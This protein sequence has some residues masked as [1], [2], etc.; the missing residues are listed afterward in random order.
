MKPAPSRRPKMLATRS[1]LIPRK[2]AAISTN[3]PT[4]A[5]W[6]ANAGTTTRPITAPTTYEFAMMSRP[7][8]LLPMVPAMNRRGSVRIALPSTRRPRP[9]T[10]RLALVV[11]IPT[12]LVSVSRAFRPYRPILPKDGPAYTP[13][14]MCRG[15]QLAETPPS[16]TGGAHLRW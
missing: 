9:S 14:T 13:V 5:R 16:G 2:T 8:T 15:T 4:W 10:S 7:K 3:S 1:T 12:L 11:T 6:S